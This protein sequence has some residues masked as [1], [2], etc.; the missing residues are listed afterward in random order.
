M[1]FGPA[2]ELI[3][4]LRDE[5]VRAEVK[6]DGD[7]YEAVQ[8]ATEMDFAAMRDLSSDERDAKLKELNTKAQEVMDEVLDPAGQ[9]RLMG[10][11][12]QQRGNQA[13]TNALIAKTVGVSDGD[14]KKIEDA[15]S[16]VRSEMFANARPGQGG[17][18]GERPDFRAIMEDMRKKGDEAVNKILTDEQEKAIEELK[19]A[20]FEFSEN[21]GG[22][23]GGFGGGRGGPG[24]GPGGPG[25]GRGQGGGRGRPGSDN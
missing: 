8:K 24:G 18:G 4:L 16:E 12:L 25:G 5:K 23:G 11:L 2:L 22:F 17:Q 9:K 3:G 20:K 1:S 19:G 14:L 21:A 13:V 6:M 7:T 15:I 10:L